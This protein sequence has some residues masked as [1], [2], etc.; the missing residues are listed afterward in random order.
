MKFSFLAILFILFSFNAE[1]QLK[2]KFHQL[3]K[4]IDH[5][6][7]SHQIDSLAKGAL[8]IRLKTKS[9]QIAILKKNN[10]HEQATKMKAE[11][12]A[13]NLSIIKAFRAHFKYCPVYFFFS[14]DSKHIKQ[15]DLGKVNFLNDDLLEDQS[16]TYNGDFFLIGEFSLVEGHSNSSGNAKD[17]Q[18][19]YRTTS[20]FSAFVIKTHQFE[21][22]KRP[23]PYYVKTNKT[24]F[25][26][27]KSHDSTII[28]L[29]QRFYG[30]ANNR[31][32]VE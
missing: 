8:F 2:K 15:G 32:V 7:S 16:I 6:A 21:Q 22:L 20:G 31:P 12:K 5:K 28:L 14:H 9:K 23:F 24:I 30:F 29:N 25:F 27:K 17:S 4:N 26:L 13:E 3:G 11:L 19:G 1:A 10:M 18:E